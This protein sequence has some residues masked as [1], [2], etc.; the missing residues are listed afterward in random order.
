MT[1]RVTRQ[2]RQ[3]PPKCRFSRSG[4]RSQGRRQPVRMR[5]PLTAAGAEATRY[6]DWYYFNPPLVS[7]LMGATPD[8][9]AAIRSG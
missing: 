3:R 6:S 4:G 2:S 7:G 1:G 8:I 5:V 9:I